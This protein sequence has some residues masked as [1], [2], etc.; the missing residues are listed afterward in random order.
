MDNVICSQ[1][2]DNYILNFKGHIDS[3]NAPTV[4]EFINSKKDEFAEKKLII[5][6]SQLEYI[7]SA[8]LRIILRHLKDHPELK[9]VEVPKDVYDVF[10]MTGFTDMLPIEKAFRKISIDGCEVI[11]Q[12]SNGVVYRI[13]PDTII[14]VYRNKDSLPDIKRETDLAHKALILCIPTAIPYDVVKVD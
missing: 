3:A 4:E 5:N 7:S 12:G 1:S 8:G 13:D 11:G 6:A 14:K 10:Q 2:N 9:I